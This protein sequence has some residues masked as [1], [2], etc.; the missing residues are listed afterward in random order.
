VPIGWAQVN[1]RRSL[2]STMFLAQVVGRSMESGVPDGS[3]C[4]FRRFEAGA[5]PGAVSLDGRRV[6]VELREEMESDMGGRYTL[7]RWKVAKLDG[8][9]GAA[10]IELRPDNKSYRSLRMR[11]EDGEIRVVAELLEVLA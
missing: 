2:D 6:V 5:A 10:E 7:K 8:D 1:A 11:P 3:Y 4:L 9:G